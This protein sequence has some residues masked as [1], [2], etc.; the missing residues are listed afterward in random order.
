MSLP[1]EDRSYRS[2]QDM[3]N[4]IVV[5]LGGRV[6]EAV[7]L[8]D[9]ST[10]AS[11]D[12][13]RATEI[14][15]NMVTK[16]GMSDTLGPIMFGS[17]DREVFLGRD[18]SSMRNY[19]ESVASDIDAEIKKIITYCYDKCHEII[20]T[21]REKLNVVAEHLIVREKIDGPDFEKL[22]KG[23]EI[24]SEETLTQEADT[25]SAE[26]VEEETTEN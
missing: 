13:E 15:R 6:A 5:L 16:Y 18:Y 19:S 10:G 21:N 9:I 24:E 7:V 11:N 20:E 26:T 1:S 22:M 25:S 8:G 12:I 3:L 14:A 17:S 2:K 23:E 4:D